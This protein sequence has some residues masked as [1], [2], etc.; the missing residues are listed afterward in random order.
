MNYFRTRFLICAVIAVVCR[1]GHAADVIH[2]IRPLSGL[3]GLPGSSP[4]APSSVQNAPVANET[5]KSKTVVNTLEAGLPP[6]AQNMVAS[7][8]YRALDS[9]VQG[10][11]FEYW[12]DDLNGQFIAVLPRRE[13]KAAPV[14]IRITL[15]R[16]AG[17]QASKVQETTGEAG[18]NNRVS[19]LIAMTP[20]QPGTYTVGAAYIDE[21][22][23]VQGE[24]AEY[25]FIRS[26]KRNPVVAFPASGVPIVPQQQS[27]VTDVDW[28]VRLGVPLPVNAVMDARRLAVFEDGKPIAAQIRPVATWC[29]EG[30][31][32]W[33]HVNFTAKYRGGKPADYRLMLLP[34]T[35]PEPTSPLKVLQS[36]DKITV[37]TGAIKFEVGR[38]KF[39]GI[40]TAWYDPTGKGEYDEEHPSI[41][42]SVGPYL[43]DGRL[44]RFEAAND[45]QTEVT[46][47]ESGPARV[48][49][50]AKG[51]YTNP[52]GRV[53]PFCQYVTRITACA[54][55]PMV[56]ISQNTIITYDTASNRLADVGFGIGAI[57]Q[58]AFRAG[59]DGGA[60]EGKLPEKST[61]Y[62]HQDRHDHFRLVGDAK[63][64]EGRTSDGWFTLFQADGDS[65]DLSLMVRDIWQKF[66]KEVEMSRDGLTVHFW[67]AHGHRAFDEKDE[68]D[69][70]NIYKFWAFHQG[71]L[72]N[73][74]LPNDYYDAFAD[75][76]ADETF[77][78]RPEHAL[79]GNG[80]G[81]VIGSEFALHFSPPA[82]RGEV[83][84]TA[85]L[86]Q[87]DPTA[88]TP[89]AWNAATLATGHVA[90]VDNKN[91]P[92]IE[93]AVEKGYL[94]YTRSVER[95]KAYGMWI[96][97]DV[98]TYWEAEQDRANL[99]RVWHN[100]HYHE[101]GMVWQMY[102]RTGSTDM[103]Q[104][105]RSSSDHYMNIGTINYA[106]RNPD[107]RAKYKNHL[108]GAMYHCKGLSP[109]GSEAY[110]MVRRD[111]H[112]DVAGHWI[113]PDTMLWNWYLTGNERA[114][115]VYN[116]WGQS[117]SEN[118]MYFG[119]RREA[120][121]TL[122]CMVNYYRATWDPRMLPAIRGLGC[123]LRTAEPLEKQ[124]PGPLWHPLW[125]NRYY[126]LTRD[127][128]Y[129]PFILKYARGTHLSDTWTTG[130][131]A[132]AY[133]LSGDKS[134][135][136]QHFDLLASY[137]R[138]FYRKAGDAYDMYGDG[139]GPI[140]DRWGTYFCWGNILYAF[141]QAGIT[142]TPP[143]PGARFAYIVGGSPSLL[144][145]ALE[146]K[147][148]PFKFIFDAASLG[149]DLH[150]LA[151]SFYSP[152]S[153]ELFK[154]KA[155]GPS[156]LTEARELPADG[157]T[158]LYK[159]E[160]NVHEAAV[161]APLTNLPGEAMV[162]PKATQIFTSGAEGWV[163][164]TENNPVTFTI[165]SAGKGAASSPC[166]VL[167]SAADG[168]VLASASMFGPRHTPPLVFTFDP[169]IH[170]L[171]WKID[172]VGPASLQ[173]TGDSSR[174][175]W[176]QS[177]ETI[178][179][180]LAALPKAP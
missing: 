107:G 132:L 72:L 96:Y 103:L 33:V 54:G 101:A 156:H 27:F 177:G 84:K 123:S 12:Q 161:R 119:Y 56:R 149:G 68:L 76:Y 160:L 59:A 19:F 81:L 164:P 48:V 150:P 131:S 154:F 147:D 104:W 11:R 153:K 46:V 144:V 13:D 108:A 146:T 8:I 85:Q 20:L 37:D 124:N 26:D 32:Q 174:L 92:A 86:F 152:S 18:L 28:P 75:Q 49:I 9:F 142:A 82:Q 125:I 167:L 178:K 25:K 94:S 6:A 99:H 53:D 176:G 173:W 165:S 129:V 118:P 62:L 87:A 115:D 57:R 159:F 95:G 148:Q 100:S 143:N 36:D 117:Y 97:P 168:K 34:Q 5:G 133:E 140:G 65:P 105:A 17:D 15:Q 39:T 60:K 79:N 3:A 157:E 51:W 30:S 83:A 141:Q 73:L 29:A 35:S 126:E 43:I 80:Q 172:I 121:T 21:A 91:F 2:S 166:N 71:K 98:H 74:S 151:V 47:E 137:P 1:Y 135:L 112:A 111:T 66:P 22:G 114:R 70:R 45:K 122:A 93:E 23:Q 42:G 116:M 10:D 50:L 14:R 78:S 113:D 63:P 145:Y 163:R 52:E 136:T 4:L 169:Q 179:A 175:L 61:V 139:P 67:P 90:A 162:V 155:G 44:I 130:L 64:A 69:I 127:P 110:G 134:Y 38:K 106:E 88:A 89:A 102:Y 171:P 55:Q 41:T 40:S 109:W 24:G 58:D 138:R 7:G 16:L 180:I 120:N 77:E 158:G 170:K 128:E 31:L